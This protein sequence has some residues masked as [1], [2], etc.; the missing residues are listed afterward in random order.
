[1]K[2]KNIIY[3]LGILTLLSLTLSC[4]KSENLD[5]EIVGLGG[6]TWEQGTLDQWLYTNL[7]QPYNM[8]VKYRWDG[9]EYNVDKTLVPAKIEKVQP[10]MEMVKSAWIDPYVSES[11]QDFI[12]KYG[13]KNYVLVGSLQYNPGGTVT[14]GEA[15]GGVKVTLFSVNNFAKNNRAVSQRVLKT[16][17]HEFTHILNQTISYQKEFPQITPSGYTA[18]WNNISL[19]TANAGGFISQYAQAAPTEDFAEMTSIMLTEGKSAYDAI[20]NSIVVPK[21]DSIPDPAIPPF[22]IVRESP[23]VTAQA[24]I[25]KKEQTVISYFKMSYGIEFARLQNKVNYALAQEAPSD[26]ATIFGNRRKYTSLSVDPN[27]V[28]GMSA[29]FMT[30]WASTKTGLAAVGGAGRILGNFV[31]FFYPKAGELVLRVNY[32]NSASAPFVAHFVYKVTYNVSQQITLTYVRRDANAD[33]VA[34]GLVSLTNYLTSGSFSIGWRYDTDFLEYGQWTKVSD[35]TSSF[36]G[37][38]GVI[39]Y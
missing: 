31:L 13:P 35:P 26:L 34:P 30:V 16:I 23:N 1:M 11:S 38:L 29:N 10:L 14:L 15:E 3:R 24:A 27:N 6:D 12:R 9:S 36:F 18:D 7:T 5:K 8:S 20:V 25:R 39:K 32:A 21:L 4:K 33:V 22:I 19:A 17:H 28:P 37:T 2:M